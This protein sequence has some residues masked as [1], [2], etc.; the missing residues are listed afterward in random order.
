MWLIFQDSRLIFQDFFGLST[1]NSE[2][3]LKN[4]VFL[5]NPRYSTD[6]PSFSIE[7]LGISI[8]NLG[9]SAILLESRL[10]VQNACHKHH[11]A[12]DTGFKQTERTI[13]LHIISME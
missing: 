12:I 8:E 5:E 13:F 4:Q 7:S 2:Y 3:R 6:I 11:V 1:R 10:I 9:I